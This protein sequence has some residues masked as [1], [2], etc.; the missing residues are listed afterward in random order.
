[1]NLVDY[2]CLLLTPALL[3]IGQFLCKRTA[4]SGFRFLGE[5]LNL[6]YWAEVALVIAGV[7]ATAIALHS[8]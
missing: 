4:D 2:I 7:C 1:M 8:T 5:K 6:T 3:S